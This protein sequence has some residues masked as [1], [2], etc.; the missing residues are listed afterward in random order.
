MNKNFLLMMMGGSGT[1][2]GADIPKQYIEIDDIPVFAYIIDKYSKV[3]EIDEM[4]I[5]SHKDWIDF[6]EDWVKRRTL[7]WKR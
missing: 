5:V 3:P 4:V 1:R 6:V 7:F 2:F